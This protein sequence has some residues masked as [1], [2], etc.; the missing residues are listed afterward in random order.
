[1]GSRPTNWRIAALASVC[2]LAGCRA[3]EPP[4]SPR[5][6]LRNIS[7]RIRFQ[8]EPFLSEPDIRGP[9]AMEWDENGRIYVVEDPDTR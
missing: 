3:S 6:A 7:D 8:I 4:F 9:V 1:M 5:E 2:L